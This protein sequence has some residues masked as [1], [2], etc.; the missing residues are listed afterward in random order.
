MTKYFWG[1]DPTLQDDAVWHL[2]RVD[3]ERFSRYD[4]P[5]NGATHSD[6]IFEFITILE[7]CMS[8]EEPD[9]D[10]EYSDR[11]EQADEWIDCLFQPMLNY[12]EQQGED[13]E[14]W[15]SPEYIADKQRLRAEFDAQIKRLVLSFEA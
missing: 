6:Q 2:L 9:Q 12:L 3:M 5:N 11:Y 15:F 8:K 10:G 1:N 14:D 13:G 7:E 4:F